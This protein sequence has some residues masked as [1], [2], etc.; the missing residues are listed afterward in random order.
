[1]ITIC[2]HRF[3]T[4]GYT[5]YRHDKKEYLHLKVLF[6]VEKRFAMKNFVCMYKFIIASIYAIGVIINIIDSCV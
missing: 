5:K 2:Y 3:H 4:I 6:F 1:M